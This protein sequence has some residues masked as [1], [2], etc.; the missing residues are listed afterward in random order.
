MAMQFTLKQ[1]RVF[2]AISE[3]GS[4]TAAGKALAL[5]QSAISSSLQQ[6]EENIGHRL[7][8]RVGR[9]LILSR[10]GQSRLPSVSDLPNQAIELDQQFLGNTV[11]GVIEIGASFTIA[12]HVIV[13]AMVDFQKQL[14][15][16]EIRITSDNSPGI[17][18]RLAAGDLDFGLIESP[19]ADPT[20]F[21]TPWLEDELVVCASP[22]HPLAVK[23]EASM[24]DLVTTPWVL[25][26]RGS[27]ARSMFND[28]F[29]AHLNGID[30]AMEFRHNE[31]IKRAVARTV[32][33]GCLSRRV[34]ERELA[35][36]TLIEINTP[37]SAKMARRFYLIRRHASQLP[38]AAM[39]FWQQCRAMQ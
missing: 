6:L 8:E 26:E 7:F 35:D 10:F 31:P 9:Q 15:S 25:R 16:V 28:T 27:G 29:S 30:I 5:S 23:A 33:S 38:P 14:P 24:N 36:A 20:I 12:N 34:L 11:G 1:L 2:R 21:C 18:D 13:D 3:Y 19:V 39:M 22:D 4:T 32:G 17:T 37:P